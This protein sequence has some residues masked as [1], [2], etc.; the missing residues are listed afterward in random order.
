[1]AISSLPSL[2]GDG[3]EVFITA[4]FVPDGVTHFFICDVGHVRDAKDSS[5]TSHFKCLDSSL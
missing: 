1:M 5:V 2:V 3:E 4:Y